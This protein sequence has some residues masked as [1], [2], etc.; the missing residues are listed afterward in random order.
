FALLQEYLIDRKYVI[1]DFLHHYKTVL[2]A[3]NPNGS[4]KRL[5]A[6]PLPALQRVLSEFKYKGKGYLSA[7]Q[8]RKLIHLFYYANTYSQLAQLDF[9]SDEDLAV[10]LST[11]KENLIKFYDARH[12]QQ[13]FVLLQTED[14][15]LASTRLLA[16]MREILLRTMGKWVKHT[17][18]LTLLY[19]V[20]APEENLIYQMRT[21][22]GKSIVLLMRTAYLALIGKTVDVFSSKEDLSWRDYNANKIVLE[23]MRLPCAY[24]KTTTPMHRY[25][26]C[27]IH[28]AT[29]GNFNLF[30]SYNAWVKREYL[31]TN[32]SRIACVDELDLILLF[33][34]TQH[35]FTAQNDK[36]AFAYNL[37]EWAYREIHAFYTQ[38]LAKDSEFQKTLCISRRK[39]LDPLTQRLIQASALQPSDSTFYKNCILPTL[40]NSDPEFPV[41]KTEAEWEQAFKKRDDQLLVLLR[42]VHCA[43]HLQKEIDFYEDIGERPVGSDCLQGRTLPIL[44]DNQK[45]PGSTYSAGVQQFISV[46]QNVAAVSRGE[47]P[48]HFVDPETPIVLSTNILSL[49]ST[50]YAS[51]EG[52]TATAGD[53]LAVQRYVRDYNIF[54]ILK[55]ATHEAIQTTFWPHIYA[56]NFEEQ[57]EHIVRTIQKSPFAAGLIHCENNQMVSRIYAA[58]QKHADYPFQKKWIEDSHANGHSEEQTIQDIEE[59]TWVISARMT[60][61]TDIPLELGVI[62]TFAGAPH[63]NKQ[64][65]GRQGRQGAPGGYIAIINYSLIQKEY[66]GYQQKNP[67]LVSTIFEEEKQHLQG[68]LKKP[69]EHKLEWLRHNAQTQYLTTRTCLSLRIQ[70]QERHN[71][72][73]RQQENILAFMS[74]AFMSYSATN[75]FENISYRQAWLRCKR[76]VERAWAQY[77]SKLTSDTTQL[78]PEEE[79]QQR[80][81]LF[82]NTAK[83]AWDKLPKPPKVKPLKI[84][85]T[86]NPEKLTQENST[87][88]TLPPGE[89]QAENIPVIMEFTQSWM[90]HIL[91]VRNTL[92]LDPKR[93]WSAV[94]QTLDGESYKQ[95]NAVFLYF[96]TLSHTVLNGRPNIDFFR[97]LMPLLEKELLFLIPAEQLPPLFQKWANLFAKYGCAAEHEPPTPFQ[98]VFSVFTRKILNAEWIPLDKKYTFYSFSQYGKIL[99]KITDI[100]SSIG[101]DSWRNHSS[102]IENLIIQLCI[103]FIKIPEPGDFEK[104][105][106][107][108]ID[109]VTRMFCCDSAE[110]IE[111]L[112]LAFSEKGPL[113]RLCNA[114][115][116][117]TMEQIDGFRQYILNH[118][119]PLKQTPELLLILLTLK[120]FTNTLPKIHCLVEEAPFNT[121]SIAEQKNLTLLFWK[122]LQQRG[123]FSLNAIKILCTSMRKACSSEQVI[124]ILLLPPYTSIELIQNVLFFP[125]LDIKKS[126]IPLFQEA[127]LAPLS[128]ASKQINIWMLQQKCIGSDTNYDALFFST[129]ALWQTAF[130]NFLPS[131]DSQKVTHAHQLTQAGL[132]FQLLQVHWKALPISSGLDPLLNKLT[133][134]AKMVLPEQPELLVE[135]LVFCAQILRTKD[136]PQD[137]CYIFLN[138]YSLEHDQSLENCMAFLKKYSKN[139]QSAL[140]ANTTLFWQEK[141]KPAAETPKSAVGAPE[142]VVEAPE[143]VVKVPEAIVDPK[144]AVEATEPVV[145][146]PEPAKNEPTQVPENIDDLKE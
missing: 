130:Q 127:L 126:K 140:A 13:G 17:Q 59:N 32:E 123:T 78:S 121:L 111:T 97:A 120:P 98:S 46:D 105:K 16:C 117:V 141:F 11:E 36:R 70:E 94:S 122:F 22:Q 134:Y 101:S 79:A 18:M 8:Q 80:W 91:A 96:H 63:D 89:L 65:C 52:C 104:H 57:I 144:P 49:L 47:A 69:K 95:L 100:M 58:L 86:P 143:P 114:L 40:E 108:L 6:V 33:D 90:H 19:I 68:K 119:I 109:K 44:I 83:L 34:P 9:I 53:K 30:I 60:R 137:K 43:L 61:G 71:A 113:N 42:A 92:P 14:E 145:E 132:F 81:I 124:Q 139:L 20:S 88:H 103:I 1:K 77:S 136:I 21:G 31:P 84:F 28:Y 7:P 37:E 93:S 2:L 107:P 39:H 76:S 131:I 72:P 142:P 133:N 115:Y 128:E 82:F 38:V 5:Y 12:K 4:S 10:Q 74:E 138:Q 45:Q 48:D 27:P 112:S 29:P 64:A 118:Q 41:E 116:C 67:P 75:Y 146:A 129:I 56:Q 99:E 87:A 24:I 51:Y 3:Q 54:H 102:A 55:V 135:H 25:R 73:M 85:E 125:Q 50:H 110:Y 15:L 26:S 23:A 62:Q 66:A 35:N 106:I